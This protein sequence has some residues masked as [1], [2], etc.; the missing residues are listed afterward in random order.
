[1]AAKIIELK[2]KFAE[3]VNKLR[4]RKSLKLATGFDAEF[5]ECSFAL[6]ADPPNFSHG[7]V[8][9][10]IRDLFL[11]LFEL[12]VRLINFAG[13]FR[14]ELVG[15]DARGRGEVCGAKNCSADFLRERCG[16][17]RVRGDIK[18]SFVERQRF[19]DRSELV[20]NSADDSRFAPI[21]IEAGRQH[22]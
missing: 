15:T 1:T 2:T 11:C 9:H 12:A 3:Y 17:A 20:K 7:Q 13:D 8:F 10:E 22:D 6:L 21:N 19:D 18:I 14:D 16:A 5:F 4:S